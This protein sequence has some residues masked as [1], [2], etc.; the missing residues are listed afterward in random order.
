M[1]RT[2][3]QRRDDFC[4]TFLDPRRKKTINRVTQ[5]LAPAVRD[6]IRTL[7][8]TAGCMDLNYPDLATY[9][10]VINQRFEATLKESAYRKETH[11]KIQRLAELGV[12]GC[13]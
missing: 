4:G 11:S 7:W 12:R 9:L 6:S 13:N 8:K 5:R 1:K 10:G 2:L 3:S